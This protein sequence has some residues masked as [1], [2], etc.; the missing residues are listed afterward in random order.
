MGL[1]R[2]RARIKVQILIRGR[3]GEGWYDVERALK[4]DPGA[5]LGQ[6]VDEGPRRG[7]PFDDVLRLSPHLADTLMLNGERCPLSENRERPLQDGDRI[8]L[9]A[10]IVG[11]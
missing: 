6:L 11:G 9:L 10:P 8:Y 7:V 2:R 4:L 5:T 3:I 1:F